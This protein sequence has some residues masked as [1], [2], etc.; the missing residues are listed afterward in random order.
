MKRIVFFVVIVALCVFGVAAQQADGKVVVQTYKF[1][2]KTADRAAQVIRP[3][4]SSEGSVSIQPGSNTLIISD[5]AANVAQIT[6]AIDEYDVPSRTFKLEIRL[7]AA[8][9]VTGEPPAVPADLKEISTKLSGVLR[10]NAFEK[11]GELMVAGREGDAV[12]RDIDGGYHAELTIGE[13]DPVTGSVQLSEFRLGRYQQTAA[14][15]KELTELLKT[16]LNLKVGQTLVLGAS[17]LPESNRA[18]MLIVV[19]RQ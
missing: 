4:L 7:V 19:A 11:V 15:R 1:K 8:G 13:Y 5:R 10:F 6:G 3:L 14:G 2:F 17:K 18:L 9:R 12:K 16:T